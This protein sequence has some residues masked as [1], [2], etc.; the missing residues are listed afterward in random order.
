MNTM[1]ITIGVMPIS[2]DGLIVLRVIF[3]NE[4]GVESE[5]A[6]NNQSLKAEFSNLC[7][8]CEGERVLPKHNLVIRP[9]D[10]NVEVFRIGPGK[11][12]I[13][14]LVGVAKQGELIFPGARYNIES[15]KTYMFQFQFH[16]VSSNAVRVE[17][18]VS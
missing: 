15:G 2:R 1:N 8:T 7:V 18:L 11:T 3:F 12:L 9:K 5:L 4:T 6:F 14:D 16:G 17:G 10:I 13:F